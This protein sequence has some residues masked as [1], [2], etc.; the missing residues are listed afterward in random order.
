MCILILA[1]PLVEVLSLI[2]G[3]VHVLGVSSIIL[4]AALVAGVAV[5]HLVHIVLALK[6]SIVLAIRSK[7]LAKGGL[8]LRGVRARILGRVRVELAVA[9]WRKR[10]PLSLVVV[11]HYC[12]G[13]QKLIFYRR[14]H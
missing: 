9:L 8:V 13:F 14:W 7:L 11:A 5:I 3:R 12:F 4:A 1:L 2:K 6:T 10:R